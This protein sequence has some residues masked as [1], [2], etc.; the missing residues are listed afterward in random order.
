V[1]E[2]S[3]QDDAILT[4]VERQAAAMRDGR[5]DACLAQ[6]TDDAI[7]L[8]PNLLPKTGAE[9]RDWM[10]DFLR[11]FRVEW[12][13]F[14]HDEMTVGRDLAYHRYSYTWRVTPRD[15][16]ASTVAS[17]KGLQILRRARDGSWRIAREIWNANPAP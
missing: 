15:G 9:L 12:L 13:S 10:S 11:R 17:G 6:Y 8:P 7:L 14:N 5:S 2:E 16:G 4:V 3:R 1:L